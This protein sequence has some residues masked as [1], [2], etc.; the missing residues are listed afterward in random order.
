MEWGFLGKVKMGLGFSERWVGLM[1]ECVSTVT[2]NVLV[3]GREWGPIV[4]IGV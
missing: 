2:Y 4:P 1:R 3:E